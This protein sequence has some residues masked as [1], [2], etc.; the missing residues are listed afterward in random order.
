MYAFTKADFGIWLAEIDRFIRED[1]LDR[2]AED[3]FNNVSGRIRLRPL[4]FDEFCMEIDTI[5]D[6]ETA[7]KI[8]MRRG[9]G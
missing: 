9:T 3:A 6:L 1:R 4:Y 7:R 8:V 2:Y 5:E